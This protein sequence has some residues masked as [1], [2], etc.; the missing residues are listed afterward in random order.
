MQSSKLQLKIK[1]IKNNVT[2]APH[3]SF[4]IGGPAKYF[5]EAKSTQDIIKAV[6]AAR[7]LNIPY[8]ILG[9][10]SNILISDKGF[11]GLVIKMQNT[12]Y[13]IQNTKI[14]ADAGVKLSEIVD[15]A[16]KNNLSGLEWAVGIPG[17][18]GGAVRGN[19]GAFGSSMSDIVK[20]VK[21]LKLSNTATPGIANFS[22]RLS[23]IAIEQYNNRAM[24]FDYRDSIFKHNNDTILSVELQ[25]KKD[26]KN[27]IKKRVKKYLTHR[28]KTQ[29]IEE[30]SA[31]CIFK[32]IYP[33]RLTKSNGA[34]TKLNKPLTFLKKVRGKPAAQLIEK[35]DLK[36]KQ[37]GGAMVSK[38]HAN[39][40][41]NTG[42]AKAEDVIIL[43][44]LIK[45]RIR[46]KFGVQL[47][48]EIEYI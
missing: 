16:T 34:R 9:G 38:K 8:F 29:P 37:I 2:L 36:G 33:V 41:I 22:S 43:I 20:K 46:N 27:E 4:G 48:E 18:V 31:G 17:T 47:Q 7:E 21:V 13:K 25:L 6:K 26:D 3:T 23:N 45:A 10:G 12:K 39:F 11:D 14:V 42:K 15:L 28:K 30:H 19:A 35:A 1:N 24:D 32:N 5:Y 44:S 40:I